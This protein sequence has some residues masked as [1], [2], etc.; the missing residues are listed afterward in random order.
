MST[1]IDGHGVTPAR[2]PGVADRPAPHLRVPDVTPAPPT[3]GP[4]PPPRPPWW[5]ENVGAGRWAGVEADLLALP[6]SRRADRSP[7][8]LQILGAR[9][10]ESSHEHYLA[11]LLDPREDHG[12]GAGLLAALLEL[13]GRPDL[14]ADPRL[15]RTRLHRQV[16]GD[17]S[18]PDLVATG[19]AASVVVELKIDAPEGHRQTT[20]QADDFAGL[21]QSAVFVYLTPDGTAP[22]DGRFRPVAQRDLAGRLARL[23]ARTSTGP[24]AA[25][26]DGAGP[27]AAG[28]RHAEDYL[29]DL[30]AVVGISTDDDEDA[31]FWA[32]H[33]TA[34]LA[35]QAATRRL[36]TRLPAHTGV[37]LAALA[38]GLGADLVVGH[39]DYTT[40]GGHAESA[41]VLSRPGWLADGV[42]Q[43]GFGLG[44]RRRS[45]GTQGPDL[46]GAAQHPF[47]GIYCTH[48]AVRAELGRRLAHRGWGGHWAWWQYAELTPQPAGT[49]FLDHNA[50]NVGAAVRDSWLDHIAAVDAL[51]AA[52]HTL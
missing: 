36:L 25:G 46:D 9:R 7:T 8:P 44:I 32:T 52:R 51:W 10:R 20:R 28:R 29:N 38:D 15:D 47:H 2:P 48:P 43:L 39:V 6:R 34:L 22:G 33:R 26:P 45:G 13:A 21:A 40:S 18:R 12:L 42:P 50:A 16:S 31:R 24:D 3:G 37:A 1:D 11:F 4:N 41:V 27:G 19:P 35:A 30:E 14:A 23:L 17:A 5:E 49:G